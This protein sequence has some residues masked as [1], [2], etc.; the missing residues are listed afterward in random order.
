MPSGTASDDSAMSDAA[1][2][3]GDLARVTIGVAV[4]PELAFRLFTDEIGLWW[5][6]GPRFRAAPGETGLIALEPRV[7]GRVF[8][9]WTDAGTERVH[10]I[11]RVLAW[12]PPRR[13]VFSWRTTNFAPGEGTE[14]EVLFEPTDAGTQVT[15]THSGFA[16]L[17]TDHPVRHGKAGADFSRQLGL[18]WGDLLRAWRQHC[19]TAAQR[20]EDGASRIL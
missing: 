2:P 20:R 3:S 8:E 1:A 10:D 6:R 18:W 19:A 7:G 11:G 9:S 5:R 15:V 13:L 14:V 12:E 4:A 17:R 16:A